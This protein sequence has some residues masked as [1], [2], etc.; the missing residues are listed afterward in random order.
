MTNETLFDGTVVGALPAVSF[1]ETQLEAAR[2]VLRT[3][4][5]LALDNPHAM[6]GR[7]CKCRDCFCC[8]AAEVVAIVARKG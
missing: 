8:A 5:V 4:G 7:R 2:K 3:Q 6:I 1:Y